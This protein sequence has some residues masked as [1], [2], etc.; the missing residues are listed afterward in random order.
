MAWLTVIWPS[1]KMAPAVLVGLVIPE[2]PALHGEGPVAVDG[3]AL[4]D[5]VTAA[6]GEVHVDHGEVDGGLGCDVLEM[7]LADQKSWDPYVAAEWPNIRRWLNTA[8]TS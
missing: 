8:T 7:V 6:V 1:V 3:A 2:G 4:S 5:A